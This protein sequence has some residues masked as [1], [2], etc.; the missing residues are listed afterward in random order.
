V[1]ASTFE[2]PQGPAVWVTME[3]RPRALAKCS[4]GCSMCLHVPTPCSSHITPSTSRDMETVSKMGHTITVGLPMLKVRR[5]NPPHGSEPPRSTR[6]KDEATQ[7]VATNRHIQ[8]PIMGTQHLQASYMSL[9]REVSLTPSMDW[10]L[11]IW[12]F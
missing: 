10:H 3:A 1:C 11:P 6:A 9:D 2:C 8:S 5:Q 12:V 4:K 7:G